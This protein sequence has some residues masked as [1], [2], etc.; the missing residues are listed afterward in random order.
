[1]LCMRRFRRPRRLLRAY[2]PQCSLSFKDA[3][4][5]AYVDGQLCGFSASLK[6]SLFDFQVHEIDP[7]GHELHLLDDEGRPEAPN[8]GIWYLHFRLYKEGMDTL[9]ALSRVGKAL[10]RPP[11]H[12][13]FAGH[14]DRC[15]VTVQQVSCSS[16]RPQEL[17]HAMQQEEWDSRLQLSH[18]Q[19]KRRPLHLGDLSGNRFQVVL[20][21]VDQEASLVEAHLHKLEE[22]GFLNYFGTQRF[23][24][25][26]IRGY[27]VGSAL[28]SHDFP[29]AV[30]LI[31]GDVRALPERSEAPECPELRWDEA[32]Q[33]AQQRVL[34]AWH[35]GPHEV[36]EA[37]KEALD[38][39]P[40]R[41]HLERGDTAE[42]AAAAAHAVCEISAKFAVQRGGW[43]LIEVQE[44]FRHNLE[45]RRSSPSALP[46]APP[47]ATGR[48]QEVRCGEGTARPR[49]SRRSAS[50][51]WMGPG[52]WSCPCLV[53]P[54]TTRL[55]SVGSMKLLQRSSW[56][57]PW[58]LFIAGFHC[59]SHSEEPI[60]QKWRGFKTSPGN[61]LTLRRPWHCS[62]A[63]GACCGPTGI[64]GEATWSRTRRL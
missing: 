25:Q 54:S 20:R 52:R 28:L 40:R 55:G 49:S 58:K 7:D 27:H 1:M 22:H 36:A 39:M 34:V 53:P 12:F 2:S 60:A 32:A 35:R 8:E 24:T 64:D 17:R 62:G 44:V 16:L 13:R 47:W 37:A 42:L 31:L 48:C 26:V 33:E 23:G 51:E 9:E 56:G 6:Q 46:T 14:K 41:Y 61:S 21:H 59:T 19:I 29:R 5:R 11:R 15:A 45:E 10:G 3:G 43:A 30:R 38:L 63:A 50:Q 18:L 57:F 4:I